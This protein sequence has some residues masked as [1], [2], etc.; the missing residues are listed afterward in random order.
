MRLR[1]FSPTFFFLLSH[2][3]LRLIRRPASSR[4]YAVSAFNP[5]LSDSEQRRVNHPNKLS[6]ASLQRILNNSTRDDPNLALS[7]LTQ[8]KQHGVS[9]NVNAYA[10]LVRILS[11]WGLDR[12]LDSVLV[13]LIKN[14]ERGFTVMDLIEAIKEEAEDEVLIRVSGALVK[15]YVSLAMFDEAIDVLFQM[16][17]LNRVPSIK[18]CNFL[19]SRLIEFGKTGMVVAL[20]RQLKQLGLCANEYTYA[21]VV[22]ALCRKGDFEGAVGLLLES[23]TVFAYKTFIDGLCAN[24]QTEKAVVL[25][26]KMID[27]KVLAGDDL[28]IAY[29]MVV[30]GF[31]NEMKTEAAESVVL[32]MERNGFGPDVGACSAIIVRYCKD[33]NLPEALGFLDLMLGKGLKIN[34]VIV[35]SVLQCYCK[36]DMC[37]EAW[38]KFKEFSGMNIF[39]DRVCYNVAFDALG[40]LGRVEEAVK[41]L[42][43]MMDKGMVPDVINYTTLID[44]YCLQGKVTDALNLIDEMSGKG[45]SPDLVTYNV[46]VSGLAR[47]GYEEEAQEIYKRMKAGGPKPNAVTHN[48]IIEGLCFARKVEVAE[49]FLS[50]LEQK[51]PDNYASLV[52]G[53][54]ESGLSKKAYKQ[55]VR[56]ERPLSKSVYNKLFFSLCMEGYLDKAL[57]V[58]KKMWA[59]RVEPGRSM[60]GKMIGALCEINNVREAQLLFDTMVERGLIPDLFT[61]TIMIHTYCRL[62]ELQKA[63]DLFEDMKQRGIKPDVVTYTVL[64]N[65][66]QKLDPETGSTGSVQG[67]EQKKR[68]S[69]FWRK[70]T[71]AGIGLDVVCYTVLIDRQCKINKIE[72]ATKLFDRMIESGL[73]PDMVA[74]TTL[75]S[76]Y[77]RKGYI[78]KAVALVTELSKKDIL[79]TE[80]FGDLVKRT[81]LKLKRIQ[82]DQE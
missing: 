25:I 55:F 6:Q 28:R 45:I 57:D 43:E 24:G 65:S 56:L 1:L 34:C 46:L 14:E 12:K 60:C 13:E 7:F 49:D 47:N 17:R 68:V 31:C 71:A 21:I 61:Y 4:F 29:S 69:E 3:H 23:P 58:L 74:Y 64:L 82:E 67:E 36:M 30:R 18:S 59:Y 16:K 20:F 33:M 79:L 11:T 2:S 5:N 10:T 37:L 8:L 42:Q 22:N 73:E 40:K 15:A 77:C 27:E 66:Y 81:A 76:G 53:Y 72:K 75:L 50:R 52:K 54:C 19:M 63:D 35:S 32:E 48:V 80:P 44:G 9:P 38:E 41:L 26:K 62:N 51:C 39:L 78:D 70:F